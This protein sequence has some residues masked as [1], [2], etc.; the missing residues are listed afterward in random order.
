MWL[1]V[2]PLGLLDSLATNLHRERSD[3]VAMPKRSGCNAAQGNGLSN[4][5]IGE[6]LMC[7]LVSPNLEASTEG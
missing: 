2:A 1:A 7:H 5:A 6:P 3:Y 4:I